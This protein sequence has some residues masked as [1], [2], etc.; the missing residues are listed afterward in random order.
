MKI[1][2]LE[3]ERRSKLRQKLSQKLTQME[4]AVTDAEHGV[5]IGKKTPE[6]L[7]FAKGML[8]EIRKYMIKLSR[9]VSKQRAWVRGREF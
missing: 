7:A 6:Q 5:R 4:Q 9:G 2:R 3:R 8:D 1:N